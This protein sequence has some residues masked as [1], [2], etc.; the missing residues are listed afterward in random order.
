[1]FEQYTVLP[2][3]YDRLNTEADYSSY[4]EYLASNIPSG[5]DVLDL[6]CGTGEMAIRLSEK[7][8]SVTALDYSSEMLSEAFSKAQKRNS[9]VFFTCQDMT[10]FSVSHLYNA[11]ISCFDS[12]NYILTNDKLL[13]AFSNC[14]AALDANG[15]FIF[16]MNAPA[17]FENLYSDNTFVIE[18]NGIFCVWENDYNRK[19]RRCRFY[20]NIFVEEGNAYKRYY[21][22]QCERSYK[23]SD[24]T[25]CLDKAGFELLSV[26]S[27]FNFSPIDDTTERYYFI[28]RKKQ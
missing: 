6:G 13:A 8:Y 26:S 11:A 10:A 24:I 18:E 22:E 14:A 20:I 25:E 1:M 7:G 23:L 9:E 3:F 4:I 21:E 16:D 12:F 15:L 17:K 2:E 5:A 27:D 19:S 28:A